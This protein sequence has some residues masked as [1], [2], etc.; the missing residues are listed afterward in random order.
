MTTCRHPSCTTRAQ[1]GSIF[2]GMHRYA[3]D[4]AQAVKAN[5]RRNARRKEARA[6]AINEAIAMLERAGYAVEIKRHEPEAFPS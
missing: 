6:N 1:A 5:E 2:C 4:R 3:R